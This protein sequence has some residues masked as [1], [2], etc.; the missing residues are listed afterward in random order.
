MKKH[1]FLFVLISLSLTAYSQKKQTIVYSIYKIN[2]TDDKH[3]SSDV[4]FETQML[5]KNID[6]DLRNKVIK[7]RKSR[8]K[9]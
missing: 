6:K 9:R 5:P 4:G 7:K 3:C 2:E 1:L 8:D